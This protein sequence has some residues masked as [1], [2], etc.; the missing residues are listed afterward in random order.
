[1]TQGTQPQRPQAADPLAPARDFLSS[2]R[3][4]VVGLSRNPRDFSRVLDAAL[5]KHGIEVVPVHPEAV[6]VD[7]RPCFARVGDISPPVEGALLLVPPAQAE[8][9]VRDCLD[10]GVR[11]IWFHRGGGRGSSSPEALALCAERGVNPVANLCPFM[12]LPGVGWPHR[13]HGWLRGNGL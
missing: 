6:E 9:V 13:L 11:R 3:V 7:G 4:A 12:V 10:A 1:M 2:R 5:R 8:S